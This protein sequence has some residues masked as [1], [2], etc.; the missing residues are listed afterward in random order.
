[1]D[2]SLV[3]KVSQLSRH[4]SRTAHSGDHNILGLVV[5]GHREPADKAG[6]VW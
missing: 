4:L 1:M 3:T 6:L 5:A 2:Q